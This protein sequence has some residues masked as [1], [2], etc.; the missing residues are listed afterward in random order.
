MQVAVTG[1][2][3]QLGTLVVRRLAGDRTI[4]R[5]ISLDVRPPRV[6]SA[7]VLSV[8][9]DVRD[10]AALRRH[11]D[12]CDAVVHLAFIV[13]AAV[14]REVMQAINVEG[15]KNVFRAAVAAGAKRI[16]YA[17]SVAAYGVTSGHPVPLVENSE[18]KYVADFAY[19]ANKY[20]VEA[21]LDELEREHP[22]V[23]IARFR[24]G[25]LIGTHMEHAL[26][27]ALRKRRLVQITDT[28]APMVWDEDVAD[29]LVMAVKR[30]VRGAFNL[31]TDDALTPA[32]MARAGGMRV[33]RAPWALA[34]GLA[35]I[36]PL[37]ARAGMIDAVD[38]AWIHHARDRLIVS[39]EKAKRELGWN[40]KC[41]TGASVLRKFVESVPRRVDPRI[42]VFMR[43]AAMGARRAPPNADAARMYADVH[44]QLTGEGG[45]DWTIAV[46]AGH[47]DI[48]GGIPRPPTTVITLRAGV[49]LELLAGRTDYSAAQ[50]TGK[51]RV[52]GEP[53]AGMLLGGM[54]QMFRQEQQAKGARG[55][56]ARTMAHWFAR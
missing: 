42:S 31:V 15:S 13:A 40:P 47:V 49:F 21:Y 24:P 12:G 17:S 11:F 30:D 43:L 20:E 4:K 6:V 44:L 10:E 48:R 18:R 28:P 33:I 25:I 54:V 14:P 35:R 46:R 51:V 1:G 29:A 23:A 19:S 5:V 7:K 27:H 36:S 34:R 56:G 53:M 16:A 41:P 32:Q 9:A 8:N 38:P 3:G 2:S 45:G 39:N 22:E 55:L 37:L 50:L 52:E 26:G